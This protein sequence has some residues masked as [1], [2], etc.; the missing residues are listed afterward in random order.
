MFQKWM[1]KVLIK[2]APSLI[3]VTTV[4][5]ISTP[6]EEVCFQN[7]KVNLLYQAQNVVNGTNNSSGIF[8][9]WVTGPHFEFPLSVTVFTSTDKGVDIPNKN[10]DNN[11]SFT[12]GLPFPTHL[13]QNKKNKIIYSFISGEWHLYKTDLFWFAVI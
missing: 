8:T 6:Y 9:Y 5:G 7:Q 1:K 3:P 11:K 4:R 12:E 13:K 10:V 2:C